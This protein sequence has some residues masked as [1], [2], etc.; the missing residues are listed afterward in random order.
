MNSVDYKERL[1]NILNFMN[2]ICI[3][4][5]CGCDVKDI[6]KGLACGVYNY[7]SALIEWKRR[8]WYKL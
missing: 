8:G 7:D 4:G 6:V 2:I 1:V 3:E 5:G